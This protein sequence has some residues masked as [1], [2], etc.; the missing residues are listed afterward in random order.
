MEL[1]LPCGPNEEGIQLCYPHPIKIPISKW[2]PGDG[3]PQNM[4]ASSKFWLG[5][6]LNKEVENDAIETFE[7]RPFTIF[8]QVQWK[9]ENGFYD[10]LM[11][12]QLSLA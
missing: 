1:A 11:L 9:I 8:T 10:G 7:L 2:V 12:R 6:K 3:N 4:L 5:N